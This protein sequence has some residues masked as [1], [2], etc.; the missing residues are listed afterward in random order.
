M[1]RAPAGCAAARLRREL[2]RQLRRAAGLRVAG[3]RRARRPGRPGTARLPRGR[4]ADR[5]A[6]ARRCRG[7]RLPWGWAGRAGRERLAGQRRATARARAGDCAVVLQFAAREQLDHEWSPLKLNEGKVK[8]GGGFY[9]GRIQDLFVVNG[10]YMAM[11]RAYTRPGRSVHWFVVRWQADDIPW[12]EFRREVLG[13][14]HPEDAEASSLRGYF[15]DH[16]RALG[17]EGPLHAGDNAVH[18]SASAFEAMVERTNWLGVRL[19]DD[20]FGQ[21]L[22]DRGLPEATLEE[23]A[24]DPIVSFEG[25]ESSLFDLFENLDG[26]GC[27]ERAGALYGATRRHDRRTRWLHSLW[28]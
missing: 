3:P 26:R 25:R 24:S 8:F 5:R 14:T 18:A 1:G 10:F 6:A 28:R 17:L 7:A 2:A 15:R 4:R 19:K 21:Q 16:W 27:L 20:P 13:S 22:I 12:K 9:C 11:R 23:W